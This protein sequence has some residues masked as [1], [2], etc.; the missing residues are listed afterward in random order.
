MTDELEETKFGAPLWSLE[1]DGYLN[2]L[3]HVADGTEIGGFRFTSTGGVQSNLTPF[4]KLQT[5]LQLAKDW[6]GPEVSTCMQSAGDGG[7]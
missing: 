5:G 1:C 2:G 3:C 4:A 6:P 7:T